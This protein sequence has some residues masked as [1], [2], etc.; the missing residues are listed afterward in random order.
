MPKVPAQTRD[1][2][3]LMIDAYDLSEVSTA[4]AQICYE[5]AQHIEENY[6]NGDADGWNDA[7]DIFED[8]AMSVDV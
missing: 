8:T 6:D 5:K 4:I 1:E 7:G 3:E 2:L